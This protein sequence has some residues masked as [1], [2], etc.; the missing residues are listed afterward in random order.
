MSGPPPTGVEHD[1]DATQLRFGPDLTTADCLFNSEIF[2]LLSQSD[3]PHTS[4]VFDKTLA[5]ATR[6]SKF[7]N[8]ETVK[9]VRHLFDDLVD[10]SPQHAQQ[11]QQQQQQR[12]A[13]AEFELASLCS[14]CPETAEQAVNLIPSLERFDEADLEKILSDMTNLRKFK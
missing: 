11:Q 10:V 6:F 8:R 14:L 3:A 12:H 5:Y 1:E 4:D 7:K 9:Q 13:M 2:M